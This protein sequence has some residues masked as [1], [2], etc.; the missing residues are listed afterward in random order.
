MASTETPHDERHEDDDLIY[1]R[2][3]LNTTNSDYFVVANQ[4]ANLSAE[5]A[6]R[7]EQTMSLVFIGSIII[8]VVSII[9]VIGSIIMFSFIYLV[10]ICSIMIGLWF[11]LSILWG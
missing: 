10:L 3:H 1:L 2:S 7:I 4:R 5:L 9:I 11:L 8:V 6:N